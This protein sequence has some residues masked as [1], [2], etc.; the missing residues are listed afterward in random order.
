[1]GKLKTDTDTCV[2]HVLISENFWRRALA[3]PTDIK[4]VSPPSFHNTDRE[5]RMA[6]EV[7]Q[8]SCR[9]PHC[10][11]WKRVHFGTDTQQKQ[12][13]AKQG[14]KCVSQDPSGKVSIC[15]S[16]TSTSDIPQILKFP[17]FCLFHLFARYQEHSIISKEFSVYISVTVFGNFLK[18][19]LQMLFCRQLFINQLC[20]CFR[21]FWQN[22]L[23]LY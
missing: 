3:Y 7:L 15:V 1:M 6:K 13:R 5:I 4:I 9:K 16:Y 18:D 19:S 21:K 10:A 22:T 11:Q 23:R 8:E 2:S 20:L 14:G 12:R 17:S